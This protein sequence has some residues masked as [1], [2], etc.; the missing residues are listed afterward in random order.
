MAIASGEAAADAM[1]SQ[2]AADADAD[3]AAVAVAREIAAI[4][5]AKQ[6]AAP[7]TAPA[8]S[9]GG[10]GISVSVPEGGGSSG[11]GPSLLTPSAADDRL[12]GDDAIAALVHEH[13]AAAADEL[14]GELH[15]L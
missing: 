9:G 15:H 12:G 14:H 2:A 4:A 1:A 11:A 13:D 3:G 8:R 10:A 5:A 7:P 6:G